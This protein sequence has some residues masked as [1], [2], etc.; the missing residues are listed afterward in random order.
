MTERKRVVLYGR[1]SH[2]KREGRSVT[3]QLAVLTDW[4]ERSDREVVAVLRD[5]GISASHFGRGKSRPAWQVAME[6]ITAGQVDELAVWEVSRST[7]DRAV[8]AALVAALLDSGAK[9]VVDG[10][11]HDPTDPD[12]GF[13]LDLGAALAVRESAMTSKR[14]LR[15]TASRAATGAPHGPQHYGLLIEYD[16]GTGR[17]VRRVIDEP[18]AA[19]VREAARRILAGETPTAVAKDL[20]ARG[21]P[22]PTGRR[23]VG[24]N[25][26][27]TI[28][29]PA[30]AGLRVYRGQVLDDVTGTW[31]AILTVD[32]YRRLQQIRHD[33]ERRTHRNGAHVKSLLVGI[34]RCG[35][36]GGPLGT[37]TRKRATDRVTIYRCRAQFCVSRHAAEVDQ[38]V[39]DVI[40]A[41]LSRPDF[42]ADLA[43]ASDDPGVHSAAEDVARLRAKLDE[44]RRLVDDDRLSLES[45]A[46]LEQ[47]TFPRLRA[48]EQRARPR[49]IPDVLVETA[50]AD[51]AVR[52]AATSISARREIVRALVEV[53]LLKAPPRGRF[54]P[55]D[56]A[57]VGITWRT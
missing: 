25:L 57:S 11:V 54:V 20:N 29:A 12:D 5:D 43:A 2:D 48:A 9:L 30:M 40:I 13:V 24:N 18:A 19:V 35:V 37:V 32:E 3:D 23:W 34:G 28:S 39:T 26:L 38:L 14:V 31:P 10:K 8:W 49:H 21:V 17:A 6:M 55:F 4:A 45:L 1:T 44:A 36:C 41:R 16:P 42:A 22:S 51:A 47:R 27:R 50:G 7:R 53:E 15:D 52:W 56:P 46:D 33:P